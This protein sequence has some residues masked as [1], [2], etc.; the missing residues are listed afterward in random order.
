M[1]GVCIDKLPHSCGTKKGLQV[2]ADTETGK[3]NGFCFSCKTF[4]ANPY[5]EEKTIE[6]VTL[7]K[8][9]TEKE[10]QA[11]IAEVSGFPVLDASSRKL[12][13]KHLDLFGIKISVSEEDGSTPQAMYFPMHKNGKLTGYYVKTLSSPKYT[14]A[15]GDVKGVEPFG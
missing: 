3:V 8:A 6:N 14:W 10:I 12:R 2:F 13:A 5:G 1:S 11:E 15:I 4:V 7:P 9:K